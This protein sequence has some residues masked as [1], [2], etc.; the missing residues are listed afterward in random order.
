M[1]RRSGW[2]L[3]LTFGTQKRHT[4]RTWRPV[5]LVASPP[6]IFSHSIASRDAASA[7]RLAGAFVGGGLFIL[8]AV[9]LNLYTSFVGD[10]PSS[11]GI[12]GSVAA[13]MGAAGGSLLSWSVVT[14]GLELEWRWPPGTLATGILITL[15]LT[16]ATGILSSRKALRQSPA[17]VLRGD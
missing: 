13:L 11:Y 2:R 1:S 7:P 10:L 16:V 4:M 14:R 3:R 12:L 8:S 9:G 5:S 17:A 15:L 6:R